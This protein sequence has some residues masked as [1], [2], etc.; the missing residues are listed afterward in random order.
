[1]TEQWVTM[2]QAAEIIGVPLSQISRL[3][4]D[5]AIRSKKD[6]VN[7]RIKLVDLVEVRTLFD[8]SDYYSNNRNK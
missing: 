5:G 4:R 7:K 1:M 6:T 2:S 8:S 3:A